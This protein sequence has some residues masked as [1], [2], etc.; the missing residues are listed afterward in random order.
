MLLVQDD[1]ANGNMAK[2][3]CLQPFIADDALNQESSG[4]WKAFKM[5]RWQTTLLVKPTKTNTTY[6]IIVWLWY[7]NLSKQSKNY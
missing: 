2:L 3:P 1:P 5:G 4:K 6:D 7:N